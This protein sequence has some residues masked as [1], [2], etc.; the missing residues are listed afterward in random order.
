[1]VLLVQDKIDKDLRNVKLLTTLGGELTG[2]PYLL[3]SAVVIISGQ[4][5]AGNHRQQVQTLA[6]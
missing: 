4:S 2:Q 6:E 3:Y 5:G 1:M